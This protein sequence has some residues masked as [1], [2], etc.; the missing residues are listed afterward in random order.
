MP[1]VIMA[2][3]EKAFLQINIRSADRDACR[4]LW[5]ENP[6]TVDEDMLFQAKIKIYRFCRVSFGLNCSPFILNATIKEH[7]SMYDTE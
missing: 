5:P 3:I 2:D 6:L 4:F 1:Y 7:L